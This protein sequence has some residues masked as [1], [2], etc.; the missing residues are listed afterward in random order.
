[1]VGCTHCG[2]PEKLLFPATFAATHNSHSSPIQSHV[3][4]FFVHCN[5]MTAGHFS[6]FESMTW[7]SKRE[8]GDGL[9]FT[10]RHCATWGNTWDDGPF[11]LP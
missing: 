4:N 6:T 11:F 2:F 5:K 7:I 10:I 9:F 3:K 8:K 1:M